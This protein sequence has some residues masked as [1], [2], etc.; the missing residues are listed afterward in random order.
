MDTISYSTRLYTKYGVIWIR[1]RARGLSPEVSE[2][3]RRYGDG[4]ETGETKER[5]AEWNQG[6]KHDHNT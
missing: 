3:R 2:M 1:N 5:M 4:N 6:T